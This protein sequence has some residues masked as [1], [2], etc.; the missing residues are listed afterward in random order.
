MLKDLF[1]PITRASTDDAALAIAERLATA[2]GAK[3]IVSVPA[4]VP[5]VIAAPWGFAPGDVLVEVLEG[6]EKEA[7][8]HAE[9]LRA[10]LSKSEASVDVRVDRTRI[11]DP[12]DALTI[13]ARYTDLAVLSRPTGNDAAITHA[14]FSAFLFG[15]GRP[16]LTVPAD[17]PERGAG[18]FTKLMLAWK[19]TRES[20]RAIH[21]AIALFEPSDAE[22]LI[23]D[24][25]V[26]DLWHGD[27]PGADIAAHLAEHG[28]RVNV[29]RRPAGSM[30][31]ATTILLHAAECGADLIVAGGYGHT[32][33]REWVLG[34]ATR[35]LLEEMEM[36]VL[37]SH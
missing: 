15:S 19:P 17:K 14:F 29:T 32:R 30:S 37:F 18:R 8:R 36:P 24:P 35:G 5:A 16:V 34:G 11:F 27:E 21:D 3:L 22:V 12:A 2:Y 7:L 13:Q 26:G 4:A 20:A 31:V 6:V 1:L 25:E 23:V 9:R 33:M 10:Q 28:L